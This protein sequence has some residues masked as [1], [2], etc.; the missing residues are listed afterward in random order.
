MHKDIQRWVKC[1]IPCQR[2]KIGRHTK[3]QLEP[4]LPPRTR[5]DRIHVDIVGSLPPSHDLKYILT[6]VDRF[7][8]WP[9][10]VPL[11]D[12][13][14]QTVVPAFAYAS[15]ARF[16]CPTT[17]TTDRGRQFQCALFTALT[18]LLGTEHI[19]T[20]AHHAAANG[21]EER[22]HRKLKVALTAEVNP[23]RWAGHLPFALI[24]IKCNLK[25][26]RRPPAEL[27]YGFPLRLPGDLLTPSGD[28]EQ[29][30]PSDYIEDLRH[31][32]RNTTPLPPRRPTRHSLR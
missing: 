6:C 9:E 24:G 23:L 29:Q 1:F 12:I 2:S 15:V 4:F 27:V 14:A 18:H 13:S 28:D 22:L 8:R 3:T 32:F 20:T 31:L 30:S 26:L 19:H 21:L 5:F 10:A 11:P 25:D 17:A 16:G 7:T